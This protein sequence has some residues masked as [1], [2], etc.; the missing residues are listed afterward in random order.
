MSS[1]GSG[2]GLEE[3]L[4]SDIVLASMISFTEAHKGVKIGKK[5]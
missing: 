4:R 5:V 3:V 1:N 2:G